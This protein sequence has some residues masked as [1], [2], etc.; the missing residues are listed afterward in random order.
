MFEK[1]KSPACRVTLLLCDRKPPELTRITHN[2]APAIRRAEEKRDAQFARVDAIEPNG[3]AL[4]RGEKCI[5]F[6]RERIKTIFD[7]ASRDE[8][9]TQDAKQAQM[10]LAH[11]QNGAPSDTS[12]I[13]LRTR[14]VKSKTFAVVGKLL[15]L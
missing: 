5:G 8:R 13:A 6:D 1:E 12:T 14:I 2:F 9:W 15:K 10:A 4:R 11:I 7:P 3:A